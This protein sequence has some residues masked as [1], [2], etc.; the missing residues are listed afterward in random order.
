MNKKVLSIIL[1]CVSVAALI[2]TLALAL[3]TVLSLSNLDASDVSANER[4]PGESIIG[5]T[6]GV[7][8]ILGGAALLEFFISLIGFFASLININ[9]AENRAVKIV[10]YVFFGIYSIIVI[11]LAVFAMLSIKSIF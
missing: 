6:V 3:D 4:L 1:L 10:S 5:L 2:A 11:L 9:I 8:A 7:V